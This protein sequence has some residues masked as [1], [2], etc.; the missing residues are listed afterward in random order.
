M[1]LFSRAPKGDLNLNYDAIAGY[2]VGWL[3]HSEKAIQLAFPHLKVRPATIPDYNRGTIDG[4]AL[5]DADQAEPVLCIAKDGDS[6]YAFSVLAHNRQALVLGKYRV[7]ETV[8]GDF[9]DDHMDSADFWVD[10]SKIVVM[11]GLREHGAAYTAR[12]MFLPAADWTGDLRKAGAD[13]W[14]TCVLSET[15]FFVSGQRIRPTDDID[16]AGGVKLVKKHR[17]QARQPLQPGPNRGGGDPIK[18]LLQGLYSPK[19]A[20]KA[21]L[22]LVDIIMHNADIAATK[23]RIK[24]VFENHEAPDDVAL[25]LSEIYNEERETVFMIPLDWKAEPS[26]LANRITSALGNEAVPLP[27]VENRSVAEDGVFAVYA[28]GLQDAGFDLWSLDTQ[29]DT[30][31]LFVARK[32]DRNRIAKLLIPTQAAA[33]VFA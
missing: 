18:L 19:E 5:F 29:S 32:K 22:K 6:G 7:D 3:P 28:K 31:C 11:G 20:Q 26:D 30:H 9:R 13:V 1:G 21:Y 10:G 27:D 23:A 15:R 17:G 33:C 24:T 8:L 16:T 2:A 25:R 4:F 14:R 12:H